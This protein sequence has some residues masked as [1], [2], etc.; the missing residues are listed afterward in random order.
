MHAHLRLGKREREKER[1]GEDERAR[2]RHGLETSRRAVCN[3]KSSGHLR[4]GKMKH[5][6]NKTR[7]DMSSKPAPS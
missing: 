3:A 5:D 7:K 2:R 1:E 4:D 6:E